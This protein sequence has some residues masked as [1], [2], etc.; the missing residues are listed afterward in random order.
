MGSCQTSRVVVSYQRNQSIDI[1]QTLLRNDVEKTSLAIIVRV[2]VA[3]SDP[4][5]MRDWTALP[6]SFLSDGL[7]K[8]LRD[9][10]HRVTPDVTVHHIA[11]SG[12]IK[13][14]S[15][16]PVIDSHCV[17]S[18][19]IR[20]KIELDLPLTLSKCSQDVNEGEMG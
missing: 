6:S 20:S 10:V 12:S 9:P 5:G 14:I 4:Y 3:E 8:P 16:P 1:Q 19:F 15:L 13:A 17:Q 11:P 7:I 2:K 18:E